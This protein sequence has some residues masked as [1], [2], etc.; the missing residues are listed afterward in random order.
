M[1]ISQIDWG[2]GNWGGRSHCYHIMSRVHI[3]NMIYHCWC[4]PWLR[5]CL[6]SFSV[7]KLPFLPYPYCILWEEVIVCS[8]HLGVC[9][10]ELFLKVLP[11]PLFSTFYILPT[12]KILSFFPPLDCNLFH[13]KNPGL[14]VKT[15]SSVGQITWHLGPAPPPRFPIHTLI[16]SYNIHHWGPLTIHILRSTD[17]WIIEA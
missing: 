3:L 16:Q 4:W 12:I 7:I 11:I 1:F 10:R 8:L 17:F 2:F 15:L 5:Q 9:S 6:S 14:F 13:G